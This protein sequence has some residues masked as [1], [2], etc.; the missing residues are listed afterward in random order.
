MDPEFDDEDG[1]TFIKLDDTKDNVQDDEEKVKEKTGGADKRYQ[2]IHYEE[3]T[4]E[5]DDTSVDKDTNTNKKTQ[6]QK[7]TSADK[8]HQRVHYEE[9]SEE[10]DDTSRDPDYNVEEEEGFNIRRK[11]VN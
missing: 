2:R 10:E 6:R 5:E 9:D 1:Y 11:R 3:D 4:E 8:R 7:D